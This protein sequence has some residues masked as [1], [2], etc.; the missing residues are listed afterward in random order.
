LTD[1]EFEISRSSGKGHEVAKFRAP[2][3]HETVETNR[4]NIKGKTELKKARRLT[5]GGC[6]GS[7]HRAGGNRKHPRIDPDTGGDNREHI[8]HPREDA[9][10]KEDSPLRAVALSESGGAAKNILVHSRHFPLRI[11]HI[12]NHQKAEPD[13]P[14]STGGGRLVLSLQIQTSGLQNQYE[15]QAEMA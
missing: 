8:A 4:T 6:N 11:H 9:S 15:L 1:R 3:Q 12:R 10:A 13:G 2:G 14:R 5:A 7:G